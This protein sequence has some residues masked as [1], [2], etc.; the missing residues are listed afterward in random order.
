MLREPVGGGAQERSGRLRVIAALEE[1]EKP[2]ALTVAAIVHDVMDSGDPP[3][4]LA[5]PFG[6]KRLHAIHL[7]ERVAPEPYAFLLV[8]R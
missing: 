4:H 2:A 1:T 3:D 5:A 7:V 6:Q 8:T